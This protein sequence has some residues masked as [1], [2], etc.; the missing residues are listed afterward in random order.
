MSKNAP[1]PAGPKGPNKP[2]GPHLAL[3]QMQSLVMTPALK[4]AIALLQMNNLELEAMIEAEMQDNPFLERGDGNSQDTGG[5]DDDTPTEREREYNTLNNYQAPDEKSLAETRAE[6]LDGD[7]LE[8]DTGNVFS[9]E[10]N[11]QMQFE[12]SRGAGRDQFDDPDF[13]FENRMTR[14]DSLF[15]HV[16]TQIQLEFA[17]PQDRMIASSL[18]EGL[19]EA[20]YYRGNLHE[21][22][23]QLDCEISDVEMVLARCQQFDPSGIFAVNLAQCLEIQ[24]REQGLLT[25]VMQVMLVNIGLLEK[26]DFKT[27]QKK[28]GVDEATLK[29]MLISLRRL[30][31]KPGAKFNHDVAQTLIPDI[32]MKKSRDPNHADAWTVELN[33]DT[34][35]RVLINR[36]YAA[37]IDTK[38]IKKEEKTYLMDKYQGAQ[39]LI[40]AMDQRAQTIVKVAAEIVRQQEGFFNYG[41]SYLKPLV[42]RDI[43][44][45]VEVHESTVSRVTTGKYMTTPRG[46]FELKYFFSSAIG[47]SNGHNGMVHSSNAIKARIKELI[48]AEDAN[49]VLSDDELA[50]KLKEENIPVARRTVMKYREALGLGS[51]VERR[52]Q[53]RV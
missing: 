28:C 46:L 24:L 50:E 33:P 29:E 20:G 1:S 4:Q 30:D 18:T 31:P 44:A 14:E 13:S 22:A 9:E 45:Q 25:P 34:L 12:T 15:D 38:G 8:Y 49:A 32:V 36:R 23:R 27:L 7:K 11:G 42:L 40:R 21:V 43:A 37:M 47:A 52:R 6:N 19:D 53:K 48:D 39:F 10:G 51:S 3:K 26:H 5:A 16:A 2:Q 17:A 41:V 35:P